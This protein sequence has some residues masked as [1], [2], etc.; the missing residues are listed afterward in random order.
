MGQLADVDQAL[1]PGL[2][3]DERPE[4]GELRHPAGHASGDRILRGDIRPGVFREIA[5]VEADFAGL[6]VDLLDLHLDLLTDVQHVAGVLDPIPT[7]LTDVQ[8]AIDAPQIDERAEIAKGPHDSFADLA[9]G[10]LFEQFFLRLGLLALEHRPAAENEIPPLGI[11][12]GDNAGEFLPDI[13]VEL[14]DA[15]RGDL[16]DRDEALDAADLDL[17]APFVVPGDDSFDDHPLRHLR[18]IADVDR[19]VGTAHLV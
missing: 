7:D 9:G 6:G 5:K 8:Q 1:D 17:Q 3:A 19:R 4:V 13:F 18:P 16:A 11:G 2:Q 12:L 10:K 14:L 15:V